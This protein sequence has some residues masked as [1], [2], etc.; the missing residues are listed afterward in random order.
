M[1]LR[2]HTLSHDPQ[3]SV[4]DELILGQATI[5]IDIE[6]SEKDV[7]LLFGHVSVSYNV[8][9]PGHQSIAVEI[10]LLKHASSGGSVV[11]ILS[12]DSDDVIKEEE[13]K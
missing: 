8:F 11:C 4:P 7:E 13:R 5:A 1:M 2:T 9:L 3:E 12:L 10:S 6:S